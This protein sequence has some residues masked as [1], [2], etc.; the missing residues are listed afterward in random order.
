MWLRKVKY[1]HINI[2]QSLWYNIYSN[3]THWCLTIAFHSN[4]IDD[5]VDE[6]FVLKECSL[7]QSVL[8]DVLVY[9]FIGKYITKS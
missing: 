3:C 5:D 1:K 2:I 4:D 9:L 6:S 8:Y 7:M